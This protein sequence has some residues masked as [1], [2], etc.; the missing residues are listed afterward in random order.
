[1]RCR[2]YGIVCACFAYL[3]MELASRGLKFSSS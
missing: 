1:L 2:L 3:V